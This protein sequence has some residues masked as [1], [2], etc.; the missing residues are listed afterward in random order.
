MSAHNVLQRST[1]YVVAS[2]ASAFPENDAGTPCW[3]HPHIMNRERATC[4]RYLSQS[5]PFVARN[6]RV[7]RLRHYFA[8]FPASE[9]H[10][11]HTK[12]FA[13]TRYAR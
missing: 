4:F 10:A 12:T 2:C 1:K 8:G 13:A 5:A 11:E 9:R 3:A 6:D 7:L